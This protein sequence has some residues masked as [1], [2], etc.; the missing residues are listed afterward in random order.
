VN[1]ILDTNVISELVSASADPRVLEW[2]GGIDQDSV[3]LSVITVGELKKGIEKLESSNRRK[4][5]ELWLE[6][7]LLVRF[8]ERILDL[9][10]SVMLVWGGLV[11]RL[12]KEGKPH[13][14]ID[15]LLAATTLYTGFTLVTRNTKHFK[16]IEIP[17]LDP[18][19]I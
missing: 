19:A 12:E 1:Y 9:D 7:D 13:P 6:E 10:L 15:S 3:Y 8:S 11:A 4:T 2:I 18:W 14:A 5:L 16:H 17:V